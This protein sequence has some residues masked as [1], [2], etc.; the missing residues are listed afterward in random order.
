MKNIDAAFSPCPND[1]FIFHAMLHGLVDTGSYR[2]TQNIFDVEQLNNAARQGRFALTKLSF[3]AYFTLSEHYRMLSSGAALG[4]GCGP[5][6]ITGAAKKN[7]SDMTIAV[8]GLHTTAYLLLRLWAGVPGKIV[9][10]PFEKII[11]EVASGVHDAGLVIH[12]GRFVY[13]DYGL[14]PL[15]DLGEWWEQETGLPI[16]LGCI[17]LKR[18]CGEP[19]N[20]DLSRVLHDSVVYA[21]NNRPASREF[22]KMHAQEMD[23]AVIDRHIGLYV[24]DFTVDLGETGR[25]AVEKLEEMARCRDLIKPE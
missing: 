5:L 7:I 23:D 11:E 14:R 25:A 16:P 6:L 17:A 22:V 2:F 19:M 20:R 21:Q 18:S 9:V 3:F 24:N 13:R 8:P 1:T 15:T 12:E 10:R 4:F